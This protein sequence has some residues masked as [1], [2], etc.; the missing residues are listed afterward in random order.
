MDVDQVPEAELPGEAV[1]P[2]EGLRGEPC[3]VLHVVRLARAEQRPQ[4]R[5]GEHA[6]VE[7]ILE[8]VQARQAIGVVP[9]SVARAQPWPALTFVKVTDIPPSDVAVAW[10]A[11]ETSQPVADF[12]AIARD[13]AAGAS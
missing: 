10:H 11:G 3:Q 6:R 4:Q 8:P 1:S 5:V 7:V 2:A 9:E 12:I 13:L